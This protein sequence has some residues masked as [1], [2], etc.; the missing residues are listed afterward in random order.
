MDCDELSR[1]S[2]LR[3]IASM[4]G[5]AAVP[6]SWA[7][8]ANAGHEAHAAAQLPAVAGFNFFSA[9]DGADVEAI[10]AQIVPGGDAPGARE[11][12]A[13]YFIDRALGSF[14]AR[15][16]PEFRTRLAEF[17][18][19]CRARF[20]DAH[21]FAALPSADQ[22]DFLKS[23]EQ[24]PFFDRVRL[25]TLLG[26][27]TNPEYGGNRDRLGW[28]LIGFED[29]HVFQPPFGHYDRDYPGFSLDPVK[30]S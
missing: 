20:G 18:A 24:T 13:V 4:L 26:L 25:L 22:I 9:T 17:Q 3:A 6:L 19:A 30:P 15:M 16:A 29:Q 7:E 12:G 27:F 8:I 11:A 2:L 28:K 10:A 21:A 14:F 1:R 5:A 23:V